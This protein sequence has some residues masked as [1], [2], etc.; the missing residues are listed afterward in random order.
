MWPFRVETFR[1]FDILL[2]EYW[3]VS[4]DQKEM[5]SSFSFLLL[6][7]CFSR[8]MPQKTDSYLLP[9][10]PAAVLLYVCPILKLPNSDVATAP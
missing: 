7:Y 4:S 1:L 10:V 3:I 8:R 2:V 5:M 9:P 6:L